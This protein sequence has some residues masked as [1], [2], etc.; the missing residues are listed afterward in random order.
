MH[1]NIINIAI[2]IAIAIYLSY[3]SMHGNKLNESIA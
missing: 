3:I 1:N 2:A